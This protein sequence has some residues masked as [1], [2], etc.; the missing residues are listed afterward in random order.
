[1]NLLQQIL[2]EEL[3]NQ[4]LELVGE[5]G[6]KKYLDMITEE[7]TEAEKEA[8][9]A[10]IKALL[11]ASKTNEGSTG[12]TDD[13]QVD[14]SLYILKEESDRLIEEAK[15]SANTV[16][17]NG[18]MSQDGTVDLEKVTDPDLKAYIQKGMDCVKE[19]LKQSERW[20][21]Q[22][23]VIAEALRQGAKDEYDI[24][25]FINLDELVLE[26]DGTIKDIATKISELKKRKPYLF[27][28]GGN[29]NEGV[30]PPVNTNTGYKPGMTF[31]DAAELDAQQ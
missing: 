15:Q 10:E 30:N 25:Q 1:M 21:K 29:N 19:S 20:I 5:D 11:D 23:I 4:L 13:G 9:V 31:A 8:V 7:S 2:G 6:I 17:L 14:M 16:L 12:T 3:Y 24:L 28:V 27:E 18:W 22:G 26:E